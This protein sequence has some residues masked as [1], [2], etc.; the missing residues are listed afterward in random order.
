MSEAPHAFLFLADEGFNRRIVAEMRR[1]RP[2][3][4]I[5]TIREAGK[6]G[7]EDPLVLELAAEQERVLLSHDTHTMPSHL[8]TFLLSGR[9]SPGVVLV[10]QEL[11]IGPALEDLLLIVDAGTPGE[12]ANLCTRLPL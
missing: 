3:L 4:D 5:L 9:Q 11:P 12:L 1:K 8:N 6:L 7:L 2:G 10:P